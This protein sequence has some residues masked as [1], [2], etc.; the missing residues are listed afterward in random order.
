MFIIRKEPLTS[1]GY[2]PMIWKNMNISNKFYVPHCGMVEHYYK[3]IMLYKKYIYKWQLFLF[4][5]GR[6]FRTFYM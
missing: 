2:G 5:I 6:P 4:A 3:K 1:S